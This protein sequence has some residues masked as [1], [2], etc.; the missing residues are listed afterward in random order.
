MYNSLSDG[1]SQTFYILLKY[2]FLFSSLSKFLG[3]EKEECIT[4]FS[5]SHPSSTVP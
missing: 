2:N 5:V 3:L 4:S 1:S